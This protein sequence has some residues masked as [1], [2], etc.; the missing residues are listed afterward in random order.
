MPS[1]P[2]SGHCSFF[3]FCL[4]F[5]YLDPGGDVGQG[6]AGARNHPAAA[7]GCDH[8]I[9]PLDLIHH[10]AR[11][12][13]LPGDDP[14]VVIGVHELGPGFGL[15]LGKDRLARRG[16]RFAFGDDPAIAPDGGLLCLGGGARHDHMAG[17][18]APSGG[19]GQAQRVVPRRMGRH[20][21][22]GH[23][24]GQPE[25]RVAGAA[26]FE[27]A[28]LLEVL[29]FEEQVGPGQVVEI[30]RCQDR[31]VVDIGPDAL[32]GRDH[33]VIGRNIARLILHHAASL[34]EVDLGP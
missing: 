14:R 5:L 8:G 17:N 16:R 34:F 33:I 1:H 28:G 6:Q 20:A 10:L 31:R 23:L 18:A 24:V 3:Y 22:L 32:M 19:I 29:A 30:G 26:H 27:R 15:D 12:G 11:T 7:N 21:F 25:D 4:F 13:A 9:E 2:K